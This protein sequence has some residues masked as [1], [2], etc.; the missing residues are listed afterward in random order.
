LGVFSYSDEDTSQ[1]FHLADKIAP[2]TIER[3]RNTLMA[4]QRKVS[5][6]NL[7]R[8]VGQ[9]MQVMLEGPS[10]DTDLVWEARHQGMAPDID[11]K[12]FITEFD[13]VT[14]AAQLPPPG[15]LATVE[16]TAAKDY[17]LIGRVT[18]FA[19]PRFAPAIHGPA[20]QNPFPILSSR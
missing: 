15:T 1:S 18:E 8:R 19:A 3:R 17:D 12:I 10:K 6:R 16:I 5:A 11:G 2:E 14:D 4:L 13:G 20:E 7:R 9:S